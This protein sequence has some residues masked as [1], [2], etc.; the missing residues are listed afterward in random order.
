MRTELMSYKRD[1][2]RTQLQAT[3]A[4]LERTHGMI[5]ERDRELTTLRTSLRRTQHSEEVLAGQLGQMQRQYDRLLG[6][7]VEAKEQTQTGTAHTN[8]LSHTSTHTNILT[9]TLSHTNTLSHSNTLAQT[10]PAGTLSSPAATPRTHT[11]TAEPPHTAGAERILRRIA[12]VQHARIAA[13]SQ[14][15]KQIVRTQRYSHI[16]EQ[17]RQRE[18][19]EYESEYARLQKELV[20]ALLHSSAYFFLVCILRRMKTWLYMISRLLLIARQHRYATRHG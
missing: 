13:L 8:A 2:A 6:A 15:L 12:S 19:T 1:H 3:N 17:R 20:C 5:S 14:Q 7:V 10:A 16:L 4:R 18:R 9:S 11:R